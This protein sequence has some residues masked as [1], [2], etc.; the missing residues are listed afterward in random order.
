MGEV[1][2]CTDREH[3]HHRHHRYRHLT[4]GK[5]VKARSWHM[6][7]SQGQ[8]I[9]HVRQSRPEYG[10]CKAVKARLYSLD[11]NRE[12]GDHRYRRHRG[13]TPGEKAGLLICKHDHL[14]SHVGFDR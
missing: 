2:L 12:H 7:D 11:G 4:P 5:T 9:A 8:N 6:S 13:L 1:T 14:V 3:E 10:T